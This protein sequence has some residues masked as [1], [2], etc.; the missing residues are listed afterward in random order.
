MQVAS[1]ARLAVCG[2]SQRLPESRRLCVA[3]EHTS[4][5]MSV[6]Q[7]SQAGHE[8]RQVRAHSQYTRKWL[9][10]ADRLKE[11]LFPTNK[12]LLERPCCKSM[13]GNVFS[14]KKVAWEDCEK[15]LVAECPSEDRRVNTRYARVREGIRHARVRVSWR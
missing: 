10:I 15:T 2:V 5:G 4:E 9:C 14:H 13:V 3:E 12:Y 8:A 6:R 11:D 1:A 7:A